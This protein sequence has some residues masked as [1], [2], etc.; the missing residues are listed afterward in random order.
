[1]GGVQAQT[2]QRGTK[3]EINNEEGRHSQQIKQLPFYKKKILPE[4]KYSGR[5]A[6]HWICSK[7]LIV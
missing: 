1:M 2:M 3:A 6:T 5:H 4:T 7:W